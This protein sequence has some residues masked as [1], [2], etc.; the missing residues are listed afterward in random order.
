[1]IESPPPGTPVPRR[2]GSDG[3][4]V[5]TP[6]RPPLRTF[7]CIFPYLWKLV[8][9]LLLPIAFYLL[10][11]IFM[12]HKESHHPS[13]LEILIGVIQVLLV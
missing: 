9:F 2:S 13:I 6:P 7:Y 10:F 4:S 5:V 11:Q 8:S 1:M 12:I 3:A